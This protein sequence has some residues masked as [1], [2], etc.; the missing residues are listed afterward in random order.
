MFS[1][2]LADDEINILNLLEGLIDWNALN[3]KIAAKCMTGTETYQR[4]LTETPDIVIIDIKM[5][6]LSGLE[7]VRKIQEQNIFPNFILISGH[8]EFEYARSAIQYGVENYLV[9]PIN[10]EELTEN[11]QQ[12]IQRMEKE[13]SSK[14]YEKMLEN[15]IETNLAISRT[16]FLKMLFL[17]PDLQEQKSLEELNQI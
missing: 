7:V 1:A 2:I 15:Q 5:P 9:K 14:N 13:R 4:I 3:I 8:K 6:G 17:S 11:L 12:I 16:H 10:K